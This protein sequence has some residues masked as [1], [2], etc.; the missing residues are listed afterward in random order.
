MSDSEIAPKAVR[1]ERSE[2]APKAVRIERSEIA[3]QYINNT[4][5]YIYFYMDV[6]VIFV[7]TVKIS[8]AELPSLSSA[9]VI[10]A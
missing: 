4:M 9:K 3:R 1:I 5:T 2:I 7:P 6:F 10:I 8:N